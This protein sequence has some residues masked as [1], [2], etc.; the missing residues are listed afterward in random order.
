MALRKLAKTAIIAGIATTGGTGIA[1]AGA[2][3]WWAVANYRK[4]SKRLRGMVVLI[5][6]ASRGLGL[7]I[8]EE[9]GNRGA[10]LAITASDASEL[11]RARTLLVSKSAVGAEDILALYHDLHR[12]EEAKRLVREIVARFGRIDILVNNAGVIKIGPIE[13]ETVEDF[14]QVMDENFFFGLEC[15]LAVLP[16]MLEGGAGHIVN[17]TSIGGKVALPQMLPYTASKFAAVGFSEGMNAELRS[18]KIYVTT[19]CPG[20]VR[21]N[22][23]FNAGLA[24]DAAREFR[25]L[26]LAVGFPGVSTSVR[27]AARKII[28]A[29]IS[30]KSEITISPLAIFAARLGNVCP[31]A[32]MRAMHFVKFALPSS[33]S[34]PKAICR[35]NEAQGG[36]VRPAIFLSQATVRRHNQPT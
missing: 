9:F 25:W 11:E 15:T 26:S 5:T 21:S 8:A 32:T 34:G 35:G 13:G 22:S 27:S 36:S 31:T 6:E 3:A 7:A 12:P 18:K 24:T 1:C 4:K 19:V 20:L 23:H 17:I 29:V 28:R 10:K 2:F 16:Q 14:R 30:R 33:A